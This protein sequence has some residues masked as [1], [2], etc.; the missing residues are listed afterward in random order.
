MSTCTSLVTDDTNVAATASEAEKSPY[1]ARLAQRGDWYISCG[2]W[3]QPPQQGLAP[4]CKRRREIL[5]SL[6]RHQAK[7]PMRYSLTVVEGLIVRALKSPMPFSQ[8]LIMLAELNWGMYSLRH[9]AEVE[10]LPVYPK[11]I[12]ISSSYMEDQCCQYNGL[13]EINRIDC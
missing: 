5:D 13:I 6:R 3:W 7:L 2:S 10:I 1:L 12:G 4:E 8:G 11:V 9:T